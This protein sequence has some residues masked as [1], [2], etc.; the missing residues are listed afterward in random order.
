MTYTFRRP[1][2]DYLDIVVKEGLE[3]NFADNFP[4]PELQAAKMDI[5]TDPTSQEQYCFANRNCYGEKVPEFENTLATVG[6]CCSNG[7]SQSWGMQ[8]SYSCQNCKDIADLDQIN[9]NSSAILTYGTCLAFGKSYYRT[10]DGVEYMFE[11]ECRYVLAKGTHWSISIQSVE[12]VS[13]CDCFKRITVMYN[14][15]EFLL[16]KG[17]LFLEGSLMDLKQEP[18]KQHGVTYM[19]KLDN[20]TMLNTAEFRLKADKTSAVYVTIEKDIAEQDT[21]LGLCGHYNQDR[22][23]D[24]LMK[25]MVPTSN[26]TTFGNSWN[27][28]ENFC[29]SAGSVQSCQDQ[30]E[31]SRAE[32]ACVMLRMNTFSQCRQY[33]DYS[34]WYQ[35][36]VDE[37]CK[38]SE[39]RKEELRCKVIGGYAHEC[40]QHNIQ[41]YWRTADT[42][43]PT[44]PQG[45]V[46]SDCASPCQRTCSNP[47]ADLSPLCTKSSECLNGCECPKGLIREGDKCVEIEQ[48]KCSYKGEHYDAGKVIRDDCNEC[49]CEKAQWKCTDMKCSKTASY[50]G[51][52]NHVTTYDGKRYSIPAGPC[53]YTMTKVDE[54]AVDERRGKLNIEIAFT[55]CVA[56]QDAYG[57]NCFHYLKL[58]YKTSIVELRRDEI[59]V[60][61]KLIEK[62]FKKYYLHNT[63]TLYIKMVTSQFVMVKGFGFHI[64]YD[65]KETVFVTLAREYEGKVSGLFGNYDDDIANE[66]QM[67]T[68]LPS[69]NEKSFTESFRTQCSDEPTTTEASNMCT[70]TIEM[71]ELC[72][73]F[74]SDVFQECIGSSTDVRD[75]VE[76]CKQDLCVA[77][78]NEQDAKFCEL[79]SALAM[80]CLMADK[81]MNIQ[82]YDVA[83]WQTRCFD[84]TTCDLG[85]YTNCDNICE[86]HCLDSHLGDK[87]CIEM[88]VPGC[89]C[90][91]GLLFTSDSNAGRQCVQ[92]QQCPCFDIYTQKQVPPGHTATHGCTNCTCSNTEWVCDDDYCFEDIDCPRNQVYQKGISGCALTCET[93]GYSTNC[94]SE[95]TFDGCEC[96]VDTYKTPDGTCVT[97][98]NCP[99]KD[100]RNNYH[101]PGEMIEHSCK[102]YKCSNNSWSLIATRDCPAVCTISGG[103][104]IQ[105]FDKQD[106]EFDNDCSYI[107]AKS[108]SP[109]DG[110]D[111]SVFVKRTDCGL[112]AVACARTVTVKIG[113]AEISMI[114]GKPIEVNGN[115]VGVN[116]DSFWIGALEGHLLIDFPW[117]VLT[118]KDYDFSIMWD[119]GTRVYLFVG[120]SW[121]D[122]V[123]GLCGNFNGNSH[124]DLGTG[125]TSSGFEHTEKFKTSTECAANPLDIN[126]LLP[127]S[128][129]QSIREKWAEEQCNIIYDDEFSECRAVIEPKKYYDQCLY[130]ACSCNTGGDCECLCTA[131]ANFFEAC[132][133]ER[134]SYKWRTPQRCPIMCEKGKV[135]TSCK[136]PC[137][138]TCQNQGEE[139]E[140]YCDATQCVEGCVCP[141]G[142]IE[143]EFEFSCNN[144]KDCIDNMYHCDQVMDCRDG[145]DELACECPLGQFK[146]DND[147]C[148][149][150]TKVCDGIKDCLD[151]LDEL[152]CHHPCEDS[153]YEHFQCGNDNCLPMSFRCD[154]VG[155]CD[156]DETNCTY[157]GPCDHVAHFR[158]GQT[159]QCLPATLKCDSHDDCGDGSDEPPSCQFCGDIES[160]Q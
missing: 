25:S 38:V 72:N 14:A 12:C 32:D 145:S 13:A 79:T 98:E 90:E 49:T 70:P 88:C 2:K 100:D 6:D 9:L 112:N 36:C 133:R 127:C 82:W 67:N 105:T 48:C 57:L 139:K 39:D 93:L 107:M 155:D 151:G 31:R 92:K 96:P 4:T 29:P 15:K 114:R 144:G 11:G 89:K 126:S 102:T 150:E 124:D 66:F 44:C 118:V 130:D 37:Y 84:H 119:G 152:A 157:T 122:Q 43:A 143:H 1:C 142:Y 160:T 94:E 103:P 64:L 128:G 117:T 109:K 53:V 27:D 40:A 7:A 35:M 60:N 135:Y 140:E 21:I 71:E 77:N 5:I 42:C 16:I 59:R 80:T 115:P 24:L 153:G 33:V 22:T 116:F 63:A 50:I 149:E 45:F 129:E 28:D 30:D 85:T 81:N 47:F 125:P 113:N 123:D 156:N 111:F 34:L 136:S 54:S 78:S 141:D 86:G 83:P 65:F 55:S 19:K 69:T 99:C 110:V 23:D 74:T 46:Y 58:T 51:V 131:L 56:T 26:P 10:F 147:V 146:C 91:D 61:G 137:H 8:G 158:C 159:G 148:I 154:G 17:E 132:S 97:K 62:N 95:A 68:G 120:L 108:T 101:Q 3:M 121:K 134:I 106:Y 73:A 18:N 20:W 104:H 87:N 52:N 75:F 76:W 138:Q 41:V